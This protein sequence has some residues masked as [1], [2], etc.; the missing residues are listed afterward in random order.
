MTA[1]L[2]ESVSKCPQLWECKSKIAGSVGFLVA[3]LDQIK[4]VV[5]CAK[6]SWIVLSMQD[7][8]PNLGIPVKEFEIAI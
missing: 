4:R 7:G 6:R 2:F 3:T 8:V 1:A 5:I